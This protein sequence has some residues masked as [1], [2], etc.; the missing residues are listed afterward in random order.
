MFFSA[1]RNTRLSFLHI[2]QLRGYDD[3]E[4]CTWQPY[5]QR[6]TFMQQRLWGSC[7]REIETRRLTRYPS[8]K[9]SPDNLFLQPFRY[10][11]REGAGSKRFIRFK[12][13]FLGDQEAGRGPHWFFGAFWGAH[14]RCSGL[15]GSLV[16]E[17]GMIFPNSGIFESWSHSRSSRHMHESVEVL[18]WLCLLARSERRRRKAVFT[19]DSRC[20][21]IRQKIISC[22]YK[23]SIKNNILNSYEH[24]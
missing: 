13:L 22:G 14:R 2:L 16:H 19:T 1:T 9:S 23:I 18:P 10:L 5:V 7:A 8:H 24:S 15:I 17:T 20:P 6:R 12:R 11:L 21:S 4:R 3:L